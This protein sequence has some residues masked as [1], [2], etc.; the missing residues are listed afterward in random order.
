V[1]ISCLLSA[2]VSD[3]LFATP[4][5][6]PWLY[7]CMASMSEPRISVTMR[8]GCALRSLKIFS[9]TEISVEVVS[10]PQKAALWDWQKRLS[11]TALG[12]CLLWHA[13]TDMATIFEMLHTS[14]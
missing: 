6:D 13:H 2:L 4:R 14:R 11:R 10:S 5:H 1:K 8:E 9:I 7:D 3:L 12:S